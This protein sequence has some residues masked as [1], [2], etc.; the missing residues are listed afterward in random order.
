MGTSQSAYATQSDEVTQSYPNTPSKN[1]TLVMQD[2]ES[3]QKT[4][5][6]H[7]LNFL[8]PRSPTMNVIRTPLKVLY[9]YSQQAYSTASE[10]L[11]PT[12]QKEVQTPQRPTCPVSY[13]SPQHLPVG[14]LDFDADTNMQEPPVIFVEDVR[15]TRKTVAKPTPTR[16]RLSTRTITPKK[17]TYSE[18]AT[19]DL[20]K[21]AKKKDMPSTPKRAALMDISNKA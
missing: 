4:S 2:V 11:F 10:T 19:L 3:P 14:K 15:P 1:E 8:D 5:E 20:G 12:P 16:A 17:Q 18:N 13:D 9:Q 21:M 6:Q 7:F